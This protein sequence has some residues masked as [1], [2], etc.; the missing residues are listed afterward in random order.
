MNKIIY[1]TGSAGFIGYYLSDKL[2]KQDFNIVGLDNINN[3]YDINLK[4]YRLEKLK[5]HEN[6][7][8]IEADISD[9]E[10][11]REIFDTYK[12]NVVINLAAQAGVRYSLE[13]PDVYMQSN[14]TGFY[15]IL[16]A[17]RHYPVEHLIY[18]S[19]SSVYGANKK[20]PFEE[21]D[22]VDHPVSL[23]A[24]TKK[25]N[26]LMAHTYS[27]LYNIPA[28]GLRFFTVYGPMG[29]PDMAY[30]SFV[31]RFFE[32][33]PIKIFNNGDFENDL[34]RDFTYIDDID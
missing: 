9:K 17:C 32:G 18:A 2:L 21:T 29:R 12:P 27:H 31:D 5:S 14:V 23:Y 25:T 20:V 13:N 34:Y 24:A 7:T 19:S 30:F 8:F 22:F 16:E 1:V 11:V 10:K 26:E 28:T 15:N 3:Y 6:F 4:K 33:K